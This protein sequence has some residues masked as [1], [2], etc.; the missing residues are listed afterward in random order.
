MKKV[1]YGLGILIILAIAG[2]CGCGKKEVSGLLHPDLFLAD[3]VSVTD[4]AFEWKYLPWNTP[5]ETVQ[6]K[7]EDYTK[8]DDKVDVEVYWA[9]GACTDGTPVKERISLA[10]LKTVDNLLLAE[11]ELMVFVEKEEDAE[12]LMETWQEKLREWGDRQGQQVRIEE[13]GSY[14]ALY[15][16]PDCSKDPARQF[17]EVPWENYS[18]VAVNLWM[19]KDRFSFMTR[20]P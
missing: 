12:R 20:I 8:T 15:Y 6:E 1:R 18:A 7:M 13:T 2:I 11:V 9:D 4:T 19:P 10:Y 17:S 16:S 14:I 3:W 5:K